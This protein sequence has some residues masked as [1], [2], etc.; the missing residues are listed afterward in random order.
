M[1]G[2]VGGRSYKLGNNSRLFLCLIEL[3]IMGVLLSIIRH[4]L[5]NNLMPTFK[6][7]IKNKQ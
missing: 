4:K 5:N 1:G 3:M 7:K 2:I 6:S